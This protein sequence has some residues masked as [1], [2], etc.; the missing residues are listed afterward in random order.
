MIPKD[1]VKTVPT[2]LTSCQR[3]DKEDLVLGSGH[4]AARQKFRVFSSKRS[5][6]STE[7]TF[8]LLVTYFQAPSSVPKKPI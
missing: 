7:S 4:R 8:Y 2:L 1:Q 5:L 6:Q 3:Q